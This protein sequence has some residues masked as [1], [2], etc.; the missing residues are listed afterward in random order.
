L[1]WLRTGLMAMRLFPVLSSTGRSLCIILV[2]LGLARETH[3]IAEPGD[4]AGIVR[5]LQTLEQNRSLVYDAGAR[6][7]C[8]FE[9]YYDRLIGAKRILSI[10][11][12][13]EVLRSNTY[14]CVAESR[15]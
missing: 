15:V 4:V 11:G 7:R 5:V 3:T 14:T 13:E 8:A 1:L 9:K 6:A 12:L 2:P 10:L